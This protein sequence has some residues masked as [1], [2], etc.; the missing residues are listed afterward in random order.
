MNTRDIRAHNP[1]R[2]VPHRG[3][4]GGY[5]VMDLRESGIVYVAGEIVFAVPQ[6]A[7]AYAEAFH[8]LLIALDALC[9]LDKLTPE[10]VDAYNEWD[11]AAG[12]TKFD[13]AGNAW[14]ICAQRS[15][16]L[17]LLIGKYTLRSNEVARAENIFGAREDWP[18]ATDGP[19][20]YNFTGER[21]HIAGSDELPR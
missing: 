19:N 6:V 8:S 11:V 21:L 16:V 1:F 15:Q 13:D 2:V 14:S 20:P 17:H 3:A 10:L 7:V 4:G 5:K 9:E 12:E 18:N